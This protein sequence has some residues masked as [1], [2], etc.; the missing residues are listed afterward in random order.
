MSLPHNDQ[1]S[2]STH[3]QPT[4]PGQSET[5]SGHSTNPNAPSPSADQ[6]HPS[7]TDIIQTPGPSGT[8]MNDLL[9]NTN[10]QMTPEES[11]MS[12]QAAVSAQHSSVGMLP[13]P[14]S[15][16]WSDPMAGLHH[17]GVR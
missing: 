3:T 15:V 6:I 7:T 14:T 1:L 8:E 13:T 9:R 10:P 5:V 2:A 12:Q 16:S 4:V 17:P 11:A